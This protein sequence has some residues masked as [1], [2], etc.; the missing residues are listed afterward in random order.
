MFGIIGDPDDSPNEHHEK[1]REEAAAD[2]HLC[3]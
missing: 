1:N 3:R 2:D